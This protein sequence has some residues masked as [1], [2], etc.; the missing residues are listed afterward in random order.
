MLE[1]RRTMQHVRFKRCGQTFSPLRLSL[2]AN[3][4]LIRFIPDYFEAKLWQ[5][6]PKLQL[7]AL[8]KVKSLDID[9]L[10]QQAEGTSHFAVSSDYTPNRYL[11]RSRQL[12]SISIVLR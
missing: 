6:K 8:P 5:L 3:E 9:P 7:C 12:R 11:V 1:V 2:S 10:R 4:L